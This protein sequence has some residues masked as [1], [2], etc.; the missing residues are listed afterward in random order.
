MRGFLLSLDALFALALITLGLSF[1]AL[2]P[3]V[4]AHA[5]AALFLAGRDYLASDGAVEADLLRKGL[6][7]STSTAPQSARISVFVARHDYPA[8]C[9]LAPVPAAPC[10]NQSDANLTSS[11]RGVWVGSG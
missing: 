9:N 4:D 2:Q 8:A 1:F 10:L 7:V 3:G 5:G 6:V 11:V